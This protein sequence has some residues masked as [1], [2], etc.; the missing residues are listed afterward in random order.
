M[1]KGISSCT[2]HMEKVTY[3]APFPRHAARLNH[4]RPVPCCITCNVLPYSQFGG[5]FCRRLRGWVW[6]GWEKTNVWIGVLQLT[7][8]KRPIPRYFK[9]RRCTANIPSNLPQRVRVWLG[10]RFSYPYPYP[11]L[12]LAFTR[13][14]FCTRVNHY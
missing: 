4:P 11:C 2:V 8:S 13:T 10:Y 7:I 12:P 9:L 6:W 5:R 3:L 1:V 14:G